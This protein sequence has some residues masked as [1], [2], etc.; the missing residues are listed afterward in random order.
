MDILTLITG[1]FMIALGFLVKAVPGLIAGYNTMPAEQKKNVDIEGLSG[2]MRNGLIAIGSGIIAGYFVFKWLGFTTIANA[3]ILVVTLTGV[4]LLV[5]FAQKYDHNQHKKTNLAYLI[6][7]A[8]MVFVAGL[9]AYGFVPTGIHYNRESVHFTGMY[10]TEVNISEIAH[11]ELANTLPEIK[12]RTN[13][14]E[15]GPVKKGMF[16]LEGIGKC[17]LLIQR[18][19]P[20]YLVITQ[21]T[22]EKIILRYKNPNNTR[23]AFDRLTI[24]RK[25]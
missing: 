24:W 17:R 14:F 22:G 18:N 2:F 1:A 4:I 16:Q 3:M 19:H 7:G 5:I 23:L 13:G 8:A 12:M 15:F 11:I 10:G 21:Q 9:I 20:P 25:P 6:L